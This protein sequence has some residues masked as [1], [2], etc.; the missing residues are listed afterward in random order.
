MPD[1][2]TPLR[3]YCRGVRAGQ[4]DASAALICF[5]ATR[6][7]ALCDHA[8]SLLGA[9]SRLRWLTRE[10]AALPWERRLVNAHRL[11]LTLL[12]WCRSEPHIAAV[13][14][15]GVAPCVAITP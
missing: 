2:F 12:K 8:L 3:A 14:V 4:H 9:T 1:P 5:E 10:R 7:E 13:R 15:H 6:L 11:R